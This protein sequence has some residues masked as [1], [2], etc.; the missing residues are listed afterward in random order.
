MNE[1]CNIKSTKLKKA[2]IEKF[3]E[4]S[5]VKKKAKDNNH[6]VIINTNRFVSS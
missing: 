2:S 4:I 6:H 3:I 1:L 5:K